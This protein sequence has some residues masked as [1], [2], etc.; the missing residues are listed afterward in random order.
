V[1][2]GGALGAFIL[3][4]GRLA[5]ALSIAALVGWL[6]VQLGALNR[7]LART[8]WIEPVRDFFTR[9]GLQTALLLLALIGLYRIS[10]IVLGVIANVFYQD[11]GF[12]KPQIA[13]A[14]KTFGVLIS[15]VGG[16]L[17]GLLAD[18]YGVLRYADARRDPRGGD[19]SNFRAIGADWGRCATAVSR[20]RCG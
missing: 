2:G 1:L 10:D 12:S 17:G 5:L 15:I 9:Y 16:L 3:E 18:R 4:T 14:V 6:L 13:T 8:V 7:A 11:I 20:G 19:Q